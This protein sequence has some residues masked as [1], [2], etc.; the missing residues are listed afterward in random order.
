M[1]LAFAGD[2]PRGLDTEHRLFAA[3]FAT[4]DQTEGMQ[5]FIDKRKPE[6]A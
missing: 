3:A 6:F 4:A 1:S 2:P 5:A